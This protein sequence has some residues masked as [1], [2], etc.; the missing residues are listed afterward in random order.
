MDRDVILLTSLKEAHRHRKMV[1][2]ALL[3]FLVPV[4][5]L[6]A[7]DSFTQRSESSPTADSEPEATKPPEL[8]RDFT[9]TTL[10]GDEVSL[11]D[12]EGDWVILNFWATWCPP[13]VS[14]MPYLQTLADRGLNVLGVNMGETAEE[15]KLFTAKHGITFPI[16][17]EPDDILVLFYQARSLPRTFLIAQDGTI[18]LRIIGPIE[19]EQLDPWLD[20]H[21][22]R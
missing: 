22:V 6:A 7:C 16:L 2:S 20:T 19:G 11:S 3:L 10:D 4:F 14:E 15:V 8:A 5:L 9:L 17:M 21:D 12:Y 1:T 18:A 13:C